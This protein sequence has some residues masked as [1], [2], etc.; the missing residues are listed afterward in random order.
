MRQAKK[1]RPPVNGM[2][3]EQ[4]REHNEGFHCFPP[5]VVR[6]HRR[7]YVLDPTRGNMDGRRVLAGDYRCLR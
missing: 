4:P 5:V 6:A 2:K 7:R 3:H 1:T